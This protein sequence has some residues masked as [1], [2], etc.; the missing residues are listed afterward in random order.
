MTA[1]AFAQF[2]ERAIPRAGDGQHDAHP[3]S[4]VL[5][6]YAYDQL[7]VAAAARVSAHV[8]TC[9]ACAEALGDLQRELAA[10]DGALA[11]HLA[12][13]RIPLAEARPSPA[14]GPI[15]R[16]KRWLADRLSPE[17][18]SLPRVVAFAGAAAAVIVCANVVLDRFLVPPVDPLAAAEPVVRWWVHLYWLLIPLGGLVAWRVVAFLRRKRS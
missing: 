1:K 13:V 17:A 12:G 3:S 6:A 7:S 5:E 2:I 9:A 16:M 15:D 11:T 10:V 4:D 8:A 18:F 14:F